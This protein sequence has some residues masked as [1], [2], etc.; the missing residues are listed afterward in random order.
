[1]AERKNILNGVIEIRA[2]LGCGIKL[3]R[4][5]QKLGLPVKKIGRVTVAHRLSLEEFI[6]NM[7]LK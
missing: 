5:Y 4:K 1:M 6:K 7:V 2:F 3:F